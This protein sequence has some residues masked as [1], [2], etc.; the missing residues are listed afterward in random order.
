MYICAYRVQPCRDLPLQHLGI[1]SLGM[2]GSNGMG[3]FLAADGWMLSKQ[4][5]CYTPPILL[6]LEILS[7]I[8]F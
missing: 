7:L 1:C 6:L 5:L 8:W 2:G 3:C 4:A